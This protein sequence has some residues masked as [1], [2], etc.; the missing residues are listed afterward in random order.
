MEKSVIVYRRKPV[1]IS[2][3]VEDCAWWIIAAAGAGLVAAV[4]MSVGGCAEHIA[5]TP[6]GVSTAELDRD[7]SAKAEDASVKIKDVQAHL[8]AMT[9]AN[10]ESERAGAIAV[11]GY[12]ADDITGVLTSS[13]AA[14]KSATKDAATITSQQTQIKTLEAADPAVKWLL[15]IGI[16]LIVVAVVGFGL[17][18]AA[19][20]FTIPLVGPL[21]AKLGTTAWVVSGILLFVGASLVAISKYLAVYERI[22]LWST[23]GVAALGFIAAVVYVL[24]E[25]GS[26][27]LTAV[28]ADGDALVAKLE[29]VIGIKKAPPAVIITSTTTGAA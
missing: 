14:T 12:A 20:F 27:A 13:A 8:S 18:V 2:D 5:A 1:T 21:L 19:G 11:A 4:L 10:W 9:A 6:M 29:A 23:I 16:S 3:R 28:E 25:H 15:G 26:P 22:F 24:Y 17:L 7:V